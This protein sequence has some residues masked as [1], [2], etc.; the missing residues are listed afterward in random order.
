[1]PVCRASLRLW[2]V[3]LFTTA[4]LLL[5][6]PAQKAAAAPDDYYVVCVCGLSFTKTFGLN[7]T[8]SEERDYLLQSVRSLGVVVP[9]SNIVLYYWNGDAK[10]TPERV[11]ELADFLAQY[12]AKGKLIVV[13]HSWGTVLAFLALRQVASQGIKAELLITLSSPLYAL[14]LPV[15]C[16]FDWGVSIYTAFWLDYYGCGKQGVL[17]P[18]EVPR[19]VNFWSWG[20]FISG[21]L[22][23][24][25][26]CSTVEDHAVDGSR[27]FSGPCHQRRISTTETWHAFTSLV[28]DYGSY[29]GVSGPPP[30]NTA[31]RAQV[32]DLI[33]QT[34][35]A[36]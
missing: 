24:V 7:L 12:A 18:L 15:P 16:D 32:R 31:L 25:G 20:D 6:A 8:E 28:E 5:A 30:Y 1:M 9:Q 3:A 19:W 36:D 33:D 10:K 35:L 23:P 11:D 4:C 13:S 14:K 17:C 26:L 27:S 22:A 34:A 2:A 21:P 29:F